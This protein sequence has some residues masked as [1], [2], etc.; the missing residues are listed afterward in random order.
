MLSVVWTE[1]RDRGVAKA[2][3][4]AQQTFRFFWREVFWERRRIVPAYDRAVAKLAFVG[5]SKASKKEEAIEFMWVD[6]VDFDGAALEGTLINEPMEL[7][8]LQPGARVSLSLDQLSDWMLVRDDAA[9]GA[10]T[11]NAMRRSMKRAERAEHDEAW[12]LD[13]GKAVATPKLTPFACKVEHP[14]AKNVTA[15]FE[16]Q[17]RNGEV[18]ADAVDVRGWSPLH[19]FALAGAKGIVEALLRNGADPRRVTKTGVTAEQLARALA[20]KEVAA[21]LKRAVAKKAPKRSA[22]GKRR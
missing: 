8:G 22:R 3:R 17:L 13:F 2:T 6:E 20:W 18:K 14:L 15:S 7:R 11:V 5:P 21:L 4:M 19:H 1:E 10:F 12:G 9:I 16:E